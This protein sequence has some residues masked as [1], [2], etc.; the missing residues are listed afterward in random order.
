MVQLL[1]L[2]SL[3]FVGEL[4]INGKAGGFGGLHVQKLIPVA[5]DAIAV[6]TVPQSP[7]SNRTLRWAILQPMGMGFF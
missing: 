3:Q 6:S 2:L 4:V 7:C 1:R 5:I